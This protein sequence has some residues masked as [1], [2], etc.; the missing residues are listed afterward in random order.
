MSARA[1]D[2]QTSHDAAQGSLVFARTQ[3][4]TVYEA[5]RQVERNNVGGTTGEIQAHLWKSGVSIERN[6]IARRLDDLAEAGRVRAVGTKRIPTGGRV[7]QQVW[8]TT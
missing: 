3:S 5:L 1:T 6:V 4:E 2:P 7:A 8:V